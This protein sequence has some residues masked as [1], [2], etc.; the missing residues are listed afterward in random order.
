M[1]AGKEPSNNCTYG[2]L[3]TIAPYSPA[4]SPR[5]AAELETFVAAHFSQV[6]HFLRSDFNKRGKKLVVGLRDIASVTFLTFLRRRLVKQDGI[7]VDQLC[8]RMALIARNVH[9]TAG[10]WK[11]RSLVM[12]E[13][14]GHP[15]LRG[16]TVG[17]RSFPSLYFE[18]AAVRLFVTWLTVQGRA[19]ELNLAVSG[20]R[21]VAL[22]A[23]DSSMCS[24]KGKFCLRVVKA[25]HVDPRPGVVARLATKGCPV[26]ALA[27]LPVAEFAAMRVLM[28]RGAGLIRKPEGQ[29]FVRAVRHFRFVAFAA[30]DRGMSPGQRKLGFLVHGY[31]VDRP[32]VVLN[33]MARFAA[34]LVSRTGELAIM[35]VLMAIEARRKFHLV[36]GVSC[37]R[38]VAFRARHADVLAFER[39]VRRLVFLNAEERWL[40]R[41][42]VVALAAFTF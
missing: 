14:R 39:I 29:D 15:A 9:M 10:K 4:S 6:A 24:E 27:L 30:G 17:A 36:D 13:S 25:V 42:H 1:L 16:V 18:L 8:R 12:V 41:F 21:L 5:T 37:C 11:R 38:N 23:S 35:L 40:P 26:R 20:Q 32:V 2:Q 34:I 19:F 22:T 7:A 33:G 31:R 28:T 3:L